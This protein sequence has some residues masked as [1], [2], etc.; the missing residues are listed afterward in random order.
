M[1]DVV[2][3]AYGSSEL[4][5]GPEYIIPKPFDPR[6]LTWETVAVAEAA[7]KSGV[8]RKKLDLDEYREQ[9]R[10]KTDWSRALMR[11]IHVIAKRDPQRI[12]FPEGDQAKIIWAASE[13]AAEGIARPILLGRRD[14]LLARFE[15]QRHSADGIEIVEPKI[16]P[17]RETYVDAYYALRQRKGLTRREAKR[18]MR[19]YYSYGAMML[20]MGDADGLVAGVAANFPDVLRPALRIV[21]P[22][23]MGG[24]VAG[25][26]LLLHERQCYC[27]ADCSVNVTPDAAA[28]AEIALLAASEMERLQIEPRVAM[29]SFDNFGSVRCEETE[30]VARAVRLVKEARPD[31]V[32]DGPVQASVALN[33]EHMREHFP[34]SEIA[35]DPSVLVF[36]S[37]DA[38]NIA[39]KLLESLSDVPVIGPL[40]MGM[41]RPV[42]VLLRD[43]E[44][45]GI[46]NLAAIACVDAQERESGS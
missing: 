16:A 27:L 37:L 20:R 14:D 1:P 19:N 33:P 18:E 26:Y 40:L 23:R 30:K 41:D 3:R 31:L 25:M 22:K 45:G 11:K 34:F 15:E 32:V 6:V 21:G 29:L 4:S 24:K 9:L 46:V 13:L 36:P 5:F 17:E 2:K 7:M 38:G 12:V 35:G 8:A 10:Q 43:S 28:L 44:V 39:L 42:Q